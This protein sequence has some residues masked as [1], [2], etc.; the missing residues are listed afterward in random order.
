VLYGRLPGHAG[1]PGNSASPLRSGCAGFSIVGLAISMSGSC[2]VCV[3][4]SDR[5]GL[6][7]FTM[8]FVAT[9]ACVVERLGPFRSM[10]RS[11]QL[12][13]GHRWKIFGTIVLIFVGG[14]SPVL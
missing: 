2:S 3:R 8:W 7:V 14:E 9:P 5:P 1:R 11:R 4:S 13:K 10:G 12:T 6:I